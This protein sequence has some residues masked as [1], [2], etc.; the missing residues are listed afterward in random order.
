MRYQSRSKY[1][2]KKYIAMIVGLI[3]LLRRIIIQSPLRMQE[4]MNMN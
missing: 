4:N 2:N 3:R 1:G